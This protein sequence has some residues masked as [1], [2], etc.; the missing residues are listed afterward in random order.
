MTSSA[1][2]TRNRVLADIVTGIAKPLS[3]LRPFAHSLACRLLQSARLSWPAVGCLFSA[4]INS[5]LG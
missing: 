1:P 2:G 4:P 3:Y 5:I